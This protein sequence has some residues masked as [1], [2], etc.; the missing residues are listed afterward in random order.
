MALCPG[1][2]RWAGTRKVKPIGILLKKRESEWQW[3]HLGHALINT[4]KYTNFRSNNIQL[5]LADWIIGQKDCHWISAAFN[6]FLD[7]VLL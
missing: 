5:L 1:L 4:T 2:P 3:H 6:H 7:S